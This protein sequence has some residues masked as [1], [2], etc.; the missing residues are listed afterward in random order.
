[1]WEGWSAYLD[2]VEDDEGTLDG[3]NRLV[4]CS[5][6]PRP[7]RNSATQATASPSQVNPGSGAGSDV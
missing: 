2:L 5:G 3:L 1:M 7:F 6:G 4:V